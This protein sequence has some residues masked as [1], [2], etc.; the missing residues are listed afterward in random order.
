MESAYQEGRKTPDSNTVNLSSKYKK[1]RGLCTRIGT[2]GAKTKAETNVEAKVEP[3]AKAL[4]NRPAKGC[5][6]SMGEAFDG[7]LPHFPAPRNDRG[8]LGFLLRPREA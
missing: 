7:A 1:I 3:K 6:G 5:I 8:A 4:S 2:Q